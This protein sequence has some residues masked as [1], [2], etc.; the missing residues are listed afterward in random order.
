ML[1]VFVPLVP[2]CQNSVRDHLRQ[3]NALDIRL[4]EYAQALLAQRL[5]TMGQ[6]SAELEQL[7]PLRDP[8]Q[9]GPSH[10]QPPGKLRPL[11]GILRPPGHKGPL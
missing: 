11:L 4:Y 5:Q 9:C 6:L 10:Y 3:L 7:G 1:T 2:V 8:K